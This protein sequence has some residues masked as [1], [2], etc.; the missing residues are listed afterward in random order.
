MEFMNCKTAYETLDDVQEKI[1]T[2]MVKS[3]VEQRFNNAGTMVATFE[4]S[5]TPLILENVKFPL[6]VASSL[7]CGGVKFKL[8]IAREIE[9]E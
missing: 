9:H 5:E 3:N 7:S 2:I 6:S 1:E 4:K 8:Q